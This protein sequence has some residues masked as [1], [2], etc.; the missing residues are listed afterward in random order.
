MHDED[1]LITIGEASP[2]PM[3]TSLHHDQP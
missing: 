3:T 2:F 1:S